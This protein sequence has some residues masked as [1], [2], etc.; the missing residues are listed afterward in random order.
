MRALHE[1]RRTCHF[2][3]VGGIGIEGLAWLSGAAQSIFQS[4]CEHMDLVHENL[5]KNVPLV[6]VTLSIFPSSD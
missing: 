5:S 4:F 1:N 6:D 3:S 2:A